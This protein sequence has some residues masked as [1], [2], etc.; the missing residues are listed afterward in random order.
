LEGTESTV[1]YI[2]STLVTFCAPCIPGKFSNIN[3]LRKCVSCSEGKVSQVGA[4][5]CDFCSPGRF[6]AS[7][8]ECK[9]CPLGQYSLTNGTFCNLCPAGTF[10]DLSGSTFCKNCPTNSVSLT[11]SISVGECFCDSGYYGV[12]NSTYSTCNPCLNVPGMSCPTNSSIP[13]V[14]SGYYRDPADILNAY[15]CIPQEACLGSSNLESVCSSFYTGFI[16]GECIP[17]QSYR[18]GRYCKQCPSL[19]S[20]VFTIIGLLAFIGFVSWRLTKNLKEIPLE[21]RMC[22]S[23]LQT[24]ALFP[25]FF[26]NWPDNLNSF[27]QVISFTNFNI[28]I[29]SPECSAQLGFWDKYYLKMAIPFIVSVLIFL[30]TIIAFLFKEKVKNLRSN[31]PFK[32]AF[33]MI[34]NRFVPLLVVLVIT[35]YTF[36]ISSTLGPFKCKFSNNQ[37]VMYDNPSAL[38]YDDDWFARLSLVIIFCLFYG[39]FL[40]GAI[41][42]MFYMNRNNVSN[43]QFIA[44]YGSLIRNYKDSYFWWDLMPMTKRAVFVVSAAFLL[45]AK[46]EVTLTYVTQF[47]LF[48]YVTIEVSCS[49]YKNHH[50]LVISVT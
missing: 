2:I 30:G 46:T 42:T 28:E 45:I 50:M 14:L 7:N 47:F 29:F 12:I 39:L 43:P 10:M 11:A 9:D 16:C 25:G 23:A 41:I 15:P 33:P 31:I 48:C 27:M 8:S 49:P 13:I 20:K 21:V 34:M 35:M 37:Y 24:I 6:P 36:L 4:T 26:S 19:V 40:P 32:H 17:F 3:T 5:Q 38:C 44:K 22:F 18:S 1:S